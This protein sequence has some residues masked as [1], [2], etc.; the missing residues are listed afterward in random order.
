MIA[1]SMV[2][3]PQASIT[4]F[5]DEV[6]T[7]SIETQL[8]TLSQATGTSYKDN[9]YDVVNATTFA[10]HEIPATDAQWSWFGELSDEQDAQMEEIFSEINSKENY[11]KGTPEQ[12]LHDLYALYSDTE[13]RNAD[14]LGAFQSY[15]DAIV[16]AGSLTEYVTAVMSLSVD[17]G[18]GSILPM[19]GVSQDELDST[20]YVV[21]VSAGDSLMGKDYY[22][23]EAYE[24][25]IQLYNQYLANLLVVNGFTQ[26]EAVRMVENTDAI[27]RKIAS[28]ELDTT[29][30]YDVEKV[31]NVYSEA[32]LIAAFPG[33]DM[34]SYMQAEGFAG[35]DMYL[36]PEE[37]KFAVCSSLLTEDNLQ[38]LKDYSATVLC[39][40]LASVTTQTA[41]DLTIELSNKL[42]G[43]TEARPNEYYWMSQTAGSLDWNYGV[44]YTENYCSK[45]AKEEVTKMIHEIIAEYKNIINSQ[46]WMSETTK[47]AAIAKLD[48]LQVK[49]GYPDDFSYYL[50]LEAPITSKKDGG[51]LTSNV[52]DMHSM[53][54]AYELSLLGKPVDKTKWIATPQTINAFY[55]P[56]NN[57][58]TILAGIMQKPFYDPD[59]SEATNLGA[60]GV[61]IGHEISHAFDSSGS[62]YDANG[63]Y[64]PWWTEEEYITYTDMCQ[65]IIDYYDVFPSVETGETVDG[66]LT[67]TENIAD[68]GGM[69]AVTQIVGH[70]KEALQEMFIS[71]ANMWAEKMTY[72]YASMLL[73]LDVHSPGRA[74][75][76]A[77][78]SSMD[79]F[80][81]AFDIQEG[82]GMYV[83]PEDRVG[84]W[85]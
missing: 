23:N 78:V 68:L 55:D 46:T 29:D 83:A 82:D 69:Y 7:T 15:M 42:N 41:Y 63:N 12:K 18:Y 66:A 61:V 28:A 57:G 80:Y 5:A 36:V 37:E 43:I 73:M 70:D 75:V 30:Y 54:K 79:A 17:T 85:K 11:G 53:Y 13:A 26:E 45:E 33:I 6:A 10:S 22:E 14:G 71:Y 27:A 47:Q 62:Q 24:P 65:K 25:Y 64:N 34:A 72:E 48:T 1:A 76:N 4:A 84:I 40:D 77:V 44:L 21:S 60:I 74:R 39:G 58:I 81:E 38:A 52:I 32:D 2:I 50:S 59:A 31:Y 3:V 20:R 51:T 49:V 8:E 19:F 9:F 16:N 67:I 35:Q 56:S